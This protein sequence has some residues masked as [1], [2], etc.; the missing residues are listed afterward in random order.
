M[1]VYGDNARLIG[2]GHVG[3]DDIHHT[4]KHPVL[5]RMSRVLDDRDDVCALLGYIDQITT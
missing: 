5:V 4:Y 2:L 1:C 3:E